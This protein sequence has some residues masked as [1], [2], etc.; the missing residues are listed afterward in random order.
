MPVYVN[1]WVNKSAPHSEFAEQLAIVLD[2]IEQDGAPKRFLNTEIKKLA[3]NNQFAKIGMEFKPKVATDIDLYNIKNLLKSIVAAAGKSKII[4]ILDEFQHLLTSPAFDNFLYALR[5]LLD[6]YGSRISVIFI[7][8]SRTGMK[9]A[10]ENDKMPF[11]QSAQINEFPILD[12]GFIAHC[13]KRLE[14]VYNIHINRLELLDFWHEINHSPHWIINLMR[15][16]V[17]NQR[18]LPQ[19]IAFIKEATRVE[20]G[21]DEVLKN[22]TATDKAVLL[23]LHYKRGLYSEESLRIIKAVGGKGTRGSIQSSERRLENKKIISTLPDKNVMI[24]LYGLIDAIEQSL[25]PELK[26]KIGI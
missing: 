12:D 3:I 13:T 15:D 24:Q 18:S 9:A 17:T 22:L 2:E 19:A 16:I 10:F 26:L 14:V 6:T 25:S 21:H 1:M 23:L 5:T 4:L 11:Y 8:S 7:G 20:E